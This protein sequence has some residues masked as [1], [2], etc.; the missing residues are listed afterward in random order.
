MMILSYFLYA[1]QPFRPDRL[2]YTKEPVCYCLLMSLIFFINFPN[3][4]LKNVL[5]KLISFLKQHWV[6][7]LHKEFKVDTVFF[8]LRKQGPSA[9]ASWG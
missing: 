9:D 5:K 1:Y 8:I 3:F 6:Q 2:D 4:C 7:K